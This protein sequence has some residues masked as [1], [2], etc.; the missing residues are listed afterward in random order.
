MTRRPAWTDA[1]GLTHWTDEH[2]QIGHHTPRLGDGCKC[3]PTR[4]ER[5]PDE[6]IAHTGIRILDPDGWDRS[7]FAEDWAKPLTLEEFK[8]KAAMSTADWSKARNA[9]G[10]IMQTT[11]TTEEKQ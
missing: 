11:P 2:G 6:W 7:N 8:R 5:T 3:G 1:A 10:R 9:W 4:E